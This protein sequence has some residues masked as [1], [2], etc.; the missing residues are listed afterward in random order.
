MKVL[1]TGATGFIGAN[2][3]RKLLVAE[4]VQLTL[5]D[6]FFRG[7]IDAFFSDLLSDDRVTFLEADLS[8]AD[9]FEMLN[10][11]FDRV[12]MLAS[13]VGVKYTEEI[14]HELVRINTALIFN[15]LEWLKKFP[16]ERVLFT[17][18]SEC[19][20]GAIDVFDV[21]TPTS[22]DVP[23]VI[24]DVTNPR[25]TYA[26]TK[27]LGEAGFFHYG[28]VCGFEVTIVRYHNV[29]GPRMGFK[30]VIPEVVTRFWKG[31][32]DFKIFGADQSRA[33]NFISDAVDGTIGAMESDVTN[34]KI[35]HIGDMRAEIK[36]EELVRYIG[37][38]MGY[39]GDYRHDN[40]PL[41]SVM[42]RCPD[43]S[44]A[45]SAFGYEPKVSWQEGV[46]RTVEW[47]RNYLESGGEVYE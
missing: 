19:Y 11:R 28:K 37:E 38:I 43:T 39:E 25:F 41:G 35:V 18:T 45:T 1:V 14:P 36:I 31:E 23:L 32:K 21:P 13:V 40:A 47:Y 5:V 27:M 42:R 4:E 33:F 7:K 22:E 10:E 8:Q 34:G 12:Y 16:A 9:A 2:L 29:Y 17:S 15:T 46:K 26:I 20:A 24:S 6:N 3:A 44:F 30:H